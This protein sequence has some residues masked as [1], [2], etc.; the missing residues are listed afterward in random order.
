MDWD[1]LRFFLAAAR[2]KTLSAAARQLG[3]NQT[4]VTRRLDSLEREL[5]VRLLDRTSSGMVTTPAGAEI[6]RVTERLGDDVAALERQVL[7]KDARLTGDLRVTTVDLV[8]FFEASLF[9]SFSTRYPGVAL[10]LS[11]G[12]F[13]RNLTRREADVAIRWTDSPPEHLVGQ[14]VAR[15]EYA[16]YGSVTLLERFPKDAELQDYPWL[17]WD[18]AADA[19]VTAAWMRRHVPGARIVCRYDMAVALHVAVRA[20]MGLSFLPCAYGDSDPALRRLR[21][22]EAGF[23]MDIWVLTHP[24]LRGT[25]RVRAFLEHTAAHFASRRRLY[26]G[27]SRHQDEAGKRGHASGVR[28]R[29]KSRS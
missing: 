21:P 7:G 13:P 5:G 16:L 27:Q 3:V 4:T 8:A 2:A 28:A 24:D 15:A 29:R 12:Y 18:S 6:L 22:V 9:E 25:A 10:E 11:V 1:H 14:R 19:R 26:A 23:G 20:G 17:A